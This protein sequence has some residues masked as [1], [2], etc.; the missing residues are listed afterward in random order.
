[1]DIIDL[2]T[3]ILVVSGAALSVYCFLSYDI[4]FFESEDE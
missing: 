3:W 4:S 2:L 1:M